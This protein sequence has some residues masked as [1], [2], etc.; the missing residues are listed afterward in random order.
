[1]QQLVLERFTNSLLLY[2]RHSYLPVLALTFLAAAPESHCAFTSVQVPLLW[3]K[4]PHHLMSSAVQEHRPVQSVCCSCWMLGEGERWKLPFLL[5]QTQQKPVY[6]LLMMKELFVIHMDRCPRDAG[7]PP[8]EELHFSAGSDKY[9][10][11]YKVKGQLCP[12]TGEIRTSEETIPGMLEG[13][14]RAVMTP[15]L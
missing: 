13:E 2:F 10:C 1:M 3:G 4:I 9:H 15:S 11:S 12:E 5:E 8:I 6:R 7:Q 14:M